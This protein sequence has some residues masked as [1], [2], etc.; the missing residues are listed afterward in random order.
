MK[1]IVYA[2][3]ACVAAIHSTVASAAATVDGQI[4][5][6]T[7][8]QQAIKL[9]LVS[10]IAVPEKKFTAALDQRM[11]PQLGAIQQLTDT[12]EQRKKEITDIKSSLKAADGAEKAPFVEYDELSQVC[13]PTIDI[14]VYMRCAKTPEGEAAMARMKALREQYKPEMEQ[15]RSLGKELRDLMKQHRAAVALLHDM[16]VT[17]TFSDSAVAQAK[18]DADGRFSLSVPAGQRVAVLASS[19][20][21]VGVE[22]E[23]YQWIVWVLAKQGQKATVTLANDNLIETGCASCYQLRGVQTYSDLPG[24]PERINAR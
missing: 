1:Q 19:K 22:T 5:V 3:L 10:V 12:I 13:K 18:T 16:I 4:F 2:L 14:S 11:K 23:H 8:G 20:R 9:A 24:P 6:V 7:K 15:V 21:A 17:D